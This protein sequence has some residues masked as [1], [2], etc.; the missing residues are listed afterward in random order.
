MYKAPPTVMKVAPP[1]VVHCITMD[2]SLVR[3]IQFRGTLALP[4]PGC[5]LPQFP[6]L[7]NSA[8]VARFE[9]MCETAWGTKDAQGVVAETEP[10]KSSLLF[11]SPL[12][13][14]SPPPHPA[15][16]TRTPK[17]R[18]QTYTGNSVTTEFSH[19]LDALESRHQ[20]IV[21]FQLNH[22]L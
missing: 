7:G 14:D 9:R 2:I 22:R 13:P 16:S 5:M 15:P 17:L 3:Q 1:R 21:T 19:R 12:T 8:L 4:F 6:H 10:R 20:F 11:T 18:V